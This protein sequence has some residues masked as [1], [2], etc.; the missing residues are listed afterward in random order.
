MS[1]PTV[2]LSVAERDQ[3]GVGKLE[4]AIEQRLADYR[5]KLES[6]MTPAEKRTELLYRIAELKDILRL[7]RPD[8]KSN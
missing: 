7:V 2:I 4:R 1:K 3:G 8:E 6:L 5:A